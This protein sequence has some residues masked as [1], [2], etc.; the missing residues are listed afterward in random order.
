MNGVAVHSYDDSSNSSPSTPGMLT[1]TT[2]KSENLGRPQIKR[3][4]S[5]NV[6][7]PTGRFKKKTTYK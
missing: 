2:T 6:S 1:T 3:P 7:K 5:L 4:T